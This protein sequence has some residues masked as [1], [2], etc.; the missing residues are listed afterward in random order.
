MPSSIHSRNPFIAKGHNDALD[1][2]MRG[3]QRSGIWNRMLAAV[4]VSEIA[5]RAVRNIVRPSVLQ[6]ALLEHREFVWRGDP[7]RSAAA[8]ALAHSD[9]RL[10]NRR[11]RSGRP[12]ARLIRDESLWRVQQDKSEI[13]HG[14]AAIHDTIGMG[15]DNSLV[16]AR[17][18]AVHARCSFD[19]NLQQEEVD[20]QRH[21]IEEIAGNVESWLVALDFLRLSR[22]RPETWGWRKPTSQGL[23]LGLGRLSSDDARQLW[24]TR[25]RL[26]GHDSSQLGAVG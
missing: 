25:E 14:L 16:S 8:R 5:E 15:L 1:A 17:I 22:R 13:G 20:L 26:L 12:V 11:L 19:R 21:R 18:I 6:A 7:K 24:W 23:R 2:A 9:P 3:I 10:K 4:W